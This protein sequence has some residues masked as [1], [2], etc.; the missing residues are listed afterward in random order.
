MLNKTLLLNLKPAIWVT[1]IKSPDKY[2]G[3]SQRYRPYSDVNFCCF[4]KGTLLGFSE[5]VIFCNSFTTKDYARQRY[6]TLMYIHVCMSTLDGYFHC[7]T[8]FLLE[9]AS[10]DGLPRRTEK[11]NIKCQGNKM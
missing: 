1:H 7:D 5:I 8:S 11:I 4:Q 3:N 6:K 9:W 10:F 2:R